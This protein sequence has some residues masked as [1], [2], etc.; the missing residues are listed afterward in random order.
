MCV[1]TQGLLKHM[2]DNVT[3]LN[4]GR[5]EPVSYN[6][7][8]LSGHHE[9]RRILIIDASP[10][11]REDYACFL[12]LDERHR[13][14][15]KHLEDDIF[16]TEHKT[17]LRGVTFSV[18]FAQQGDE[19]LNMMRQS[20][21]EERRFMI[22]F[23]D[24]RIHSSMNALHTIK[25]LWHIQPDLQVVL[26]TD[27]ST[28][29]WEEVVSVLGVTD[30]LLI[31]KKPFDPIE[32]WQAGVSLSQK[33]WVTEKRR[34]HRLVT[35]QALDD[36]QDHGH[37]LYIIFNAIKDGVIATD[38][39]GEVLYL[40]D[41]ASSITGWSAQDACGQTID[42]VV[43]LPEYTEGTSYGSMAAIREEVLAGS[44]PFEELALPMLDKKG[45]QQLVSHFIT[46]LRDQHGFPC[47]SI[48]V[49]RDIGYERDLQEQLHQSRK[50]DSLGQLAGGVAHDF[51]NLL[52][53]IVG[54]SEK[55]KQRL[56]NEDKTHQYVDAVLDAS[57]RAADLTAQLLNF[58]R[59][60]K[61]RTVQVNMHELIDEMG[62]MLRETLNRSVVIDTHLDAPRSVVAGD[63]SQL[64]NA[65]LNLAIN[66]Q[67]AMGESGGQLVISTKV[68]IL[69]E[70]YCHHHPHD[71]VPGPYVEIAL[72]DNGCGMT[73]DVQEHL[74]DPF[75]T[76][77]AVG[78]GTG[79]GLSSVYGIVKDHHGA[80]NVYSK[81]HIGT[82]IRISLPLCSDVRKET[83]N[84]STRSNE[85]ICGH[86]TILFVDDE[87]Y[88]R[89]LAYD[90]L[91]ELGYDLLLA[92]NGKEAFDIFQKHR[93]RIDLVILD[94][95]MPVWDGRRTLEEMLRLDPQA[96]ILICSGFR[97]G[98]DMQEL[99]DAGARSFV[100]KP[101]N[102]AHL[103]Q[104]IKHA[105]KAHK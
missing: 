64:Q 66:A 22:A 93:R 13:A 101:F 37:N 92:A 24:M 45:E 80:I 2:L 48:E 81:E 31:L 47:G 87:D 59:R 82:T 70:V 36:N 61:F 69:D 11:A 29:S 28:H 43:Q 18:D 65:I 96:N 1:A 86:G 9:E 46:S 73:A 40:N 89:E 33:W 4:D 88:L 56:S 68:V 20:Q 75:F 104:E 50:M 97:A 72:A 32:V 105:M 8:L 63:P 77:K 14:S 26:C 12:H 42:K 52:T 71:I 67:D 44:G 91:Q 62:M 58:S 51:N 7:Q 38:Q 98:G 90:S 25:A 39:N 35:Q 78:Q 21:L 6:A 5:Y 17:L 19:A 54:F 94:V 15:V 41:S 103:S 100:Q 53:G 57:K 83:E 85:I 95:M 3:K 74:F 102:I 30:Q 49:I 55:V 23:I 60:G 27:F 76:T 79:L 16:G 34:Q 10:T 84:V 99:M